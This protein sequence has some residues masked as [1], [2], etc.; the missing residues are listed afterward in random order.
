MRAGTG[1][2]GSRRGSSVWLKSPTRS[3]AVGTVCSMRLRV[4]VP[5]LVIAREEE[6]LVAEDRPAERAAEI[7]D[8]ERA[9]LDPLRVVRERVGVERLVAAHVAE[10]WPVKLLVPDFVLI[11]MT[12]W[13]R[14]YSAL[15]LFEMT[16]TSCRPSVFGTTE[17]SL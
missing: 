8:A 6:Q 11:E 2:A 4:V 15:K 5:Q 7:A 10:A 14:P 9:L 3:S 16:R 12:A 13:P 1:L 17:A